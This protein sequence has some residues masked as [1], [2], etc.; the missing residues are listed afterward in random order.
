MRGLVGGKPWSS[1]AVEG[2]NSLLG[3]RRPDGCG[4]LRALLRCHDRRLQGLAVDRPHFRGADSHIAVVK[5]VDLLGEVSGDLSG[6]LC[7]EALGL[8]HELPGGVSVD[9]KRAILQR[10]GLRLVAG[11]G[12]CGVGD[13][14]ESSQENEEAG[15]HDEGLGFR[16]EA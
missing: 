2:D 9:M 4:L 13:G 16:E 11:D 5:R 12:G 7:R 14:E 15:R 3:A 8:L 10:C 6:V 1:D